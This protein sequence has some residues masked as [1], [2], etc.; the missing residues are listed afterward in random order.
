MVHE[1]II[2]MD[3]ESPSDKEVLISRF[4]SL[5]EFGTIRE[6]IV[7]GLKLENDPKLIQAS[8]ESPLENCE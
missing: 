5:F 8:I 2:K 7:D 6:S 1:L 4:Y 3:I